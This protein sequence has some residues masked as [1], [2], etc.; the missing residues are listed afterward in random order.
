MARRFVDRHCLLLDDGTALEFGDDGA[1]PLGARVLGLD[2]SVREMRE[3][4]S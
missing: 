3:V 2:G 1:L 4:L